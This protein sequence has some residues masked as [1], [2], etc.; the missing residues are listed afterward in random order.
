ML[1]RVALNWQE[2]KADGY[3]MVTVFDKALGKLGAFSHPYGGRG[4]RI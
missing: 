2:I 3:K 1:S 4:E